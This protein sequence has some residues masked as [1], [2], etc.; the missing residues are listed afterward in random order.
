MGAHFRFLNQRV[1]RVCCWSQIKQKHKMIRLSGARGSGA[2]DPET[3][4]QRVETEKQQA[5]FMTYQNVFIFALT[6]GIIRGTPWLMA[7]LNSAWWTQEIMR[8]RVDIP[9]LFTI[10]S[11]NE[12]MYLQI[13]WVVKK[14]KQK[15]LE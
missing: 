3:E 4:R 13:V 7:Q 8:E 5:R 11:L 9:A 2:G 10:I 15:Y 14:M 12:Y 1:L 6:C